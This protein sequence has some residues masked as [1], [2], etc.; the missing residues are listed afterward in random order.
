MADGPRVEKSD[1]DWRA[2]LSPEAY[3]VLRQGGTER[4]WSGEYV[5]WHGS[6]T[7]TCRGC[8]QPLFSSAT[9]YESG[10]GWPS[11]WEPLTDDAVELVEDRTHGMVRVE[12][13]C[14]RC[15]SHLGHV[16][17]D[18]PAPTGQRFCMNSV[19]LQVD[20]GAR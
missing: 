9:K 2:T 3:Q 8:G 6:G 7:F 5:D 12:V 10:S 17:D 20:D 13:R 18:G 16:F 14:A 15:G 11:F 19:S 4:A 1:E